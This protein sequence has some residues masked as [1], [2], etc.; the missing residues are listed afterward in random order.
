MDLTQ[1][2]LSLKYFVPEMVLTGF[3]L[4]T[5]IYDLF[6]KKGQSHRVG[7]V[8]IVGLLATLFTLYLQRGLPSTG[9]FSNMFA[10][11]TFA[12]FFKWLVAVGAI[13]VMWMSL[14]SNELQ[15]R[16]VGEYYVLILVLVFGMFLLVSAT[17]ILSIYLALEMVSMMS[18][19][20][21]GYLKENSRS[22]E[23]SIKYVIYGAFSSG[24]MLY[25]LSLLYGLTG[26]GYISGIQSQ[27]MTG[28]TSPVMLILVTVL[29][30]A[31]F[32]YKIS[33]VPFHFWTPDVYE[34]APT[35]ITAFLSVAPKTAGFAVLIR[36]LNV[37]FTAGDPNSPAWLALPGLNWPVII[38]AL[39]ALTMTVGNVLAIQQTNIKRMLA[40]SSI[41]HAGYMLMG[42]VVADQTGISAI[43]YYAG[44]YMLMNLGAFFV[45]IQIKNLYNTET[46]SDYAGLGF[47]AP[48][49]GISMAVFMF[50]LTGLPPTGG[51]IAKFYLFRALVQFGDGFIWLA[52]VGL[53]NGVV[54]LFYYMR[55]MKAMYFEK[56][57]FPETK[58]IIPL[59]FSILMFVLVV[60]LLVG[61]MFGDPLSHWT[62]QAVHFFY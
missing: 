40:Y 53:L 31:G 1:L 41:A 42:V 11:D 16:K 60:P 54:S 24:V 6:L 62:N 22:N 44:V 52:V 45:A 48:W 23:S 21:A 4:V 35:T 27:L 17:H 29:I 10:L 51:F 39:S 19:I 56:M 12:S 15:N 30:L 58:T 61:W 46:I 59:H 57:D 49:I 3:I 32:G 47:K 25:G 5:I 34:G 18:Y 8:A 37:T 28:H 55:V 9:L 14:D 33:A 38:A 20:L 26:T 36:F 50:A 7:Y 13:F 2:A 43:L